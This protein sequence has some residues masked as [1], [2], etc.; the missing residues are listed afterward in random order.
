M[1]ESEPDDTT[2]EPTT[3]YL[4]NEPASTFEA[5]LFDAETVAEA[6]GLGVKADRPIPSICSRSTSY[7]PFQTVEDV[8]AL[9]PVDDVADRA[10]GTCATCLQSVKSDDEDD[11]QGEETEDESEGKQ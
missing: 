6:D 1:N 8:T 5:H 3:E 4:R 2:E 9:A 10:G 11:A 7:G